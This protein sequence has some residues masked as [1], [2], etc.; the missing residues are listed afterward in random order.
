M[1]HPVGCLHC[2]DGVDPVDA[3]E[4]DNIQGARDAMK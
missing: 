1:P 4:V 2:L 3:R